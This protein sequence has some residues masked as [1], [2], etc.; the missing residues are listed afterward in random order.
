MS[1]EVGSRNDEVE[2]G[3]YGAS[4]EFCGPAFTS[5][6]SQRKNSRELMSV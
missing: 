3:G 4:C 6:G 1:E 5:L 2:D